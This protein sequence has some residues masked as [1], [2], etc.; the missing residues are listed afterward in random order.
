MSRKIE[1]ALGSVVF[2]IVVVIPVVHFRWVYTH[3]KRLREVVP[4]VLYRSGELTADG[5]VEAIDRYH[6][7]TIVNLQDEYPDPDLAWGYFDTRRIKES[8][9]CKRF[10][11][12]YVYMPPDLVPHP[13]GHRPEAIERFL[14]LMDDPSAYPVLI[15]CRAGLHR[16][17]IMTAVYRMEYQGWSHRR[18]IEDLKANGFGEWPCTSANEYITQYILTYERGLRQNQAMAKLSR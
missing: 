5:F 8:E 14:K 12:R 7:R 11:V 17:G 10:G 1:W 9:L 16:T 3:G 13:I 6:F 4:G 15:H 2:L 18:A